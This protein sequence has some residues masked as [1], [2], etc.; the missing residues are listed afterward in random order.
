[1]RTNLHVDN[2]Q[3][4]K[5]NPNG[6]LFPRAESDLSWLPTLHLL[7]L[8]LCTN[9]TWLLIPNLL[10]SGLA[11]LSTTP[12]PR[13]GEILLY[14]PYIRTCDSYIG[15]TCVFYQPNLLFNNANT[16]SNAVDTEYCLNE[17]KSMCAKSFGTN[18]S[19]GVDFLYPPLLCH[20]SHQPSI[21]GIM[22]LNS[23]RSIV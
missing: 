17:E 6:C 5:I 1:M 3:N 10:C 2:R 13:L 21:P 8:N 18:T 9:P 20:S 4:I 11:L 12:P 23:R 7:S 19:K 22:N 14:Q 16:H 15:W